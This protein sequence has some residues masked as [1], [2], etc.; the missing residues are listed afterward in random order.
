MES[1]A[2]PPGQ[3][4]TGAPPEH[5]ICLGVNIDHVA[6]L[7]NARGECYPDPVYAAFIA[8]QHGADSITTHLREDRRHITDRDVRL[9]AET[10]E[11]RLNLEMAISDDI[12]AIAKAIAPSAACLVPE[13]R[14]ELTTEGGLDVAQDRRRVAEAVEQLSRV[15]TT[16]S[17]FIDPVAEQIDAAREVGAPYVE[18]H[19]GAYAGARTDAERAGELSRLR[20]MAAYAASL[21]LHVNAG[22][23]LGYHN[24]EAVAAIAEIEELNIGHSIIARAVFSGLGEAVAAM[25]ALIRGARSTAL[26]AARGA[27]HE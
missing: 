9:I 25:K 3:S 11:T 24:V 26:Q 27:G 14:E 8:Q 19:T 15:G 21:G 10:I 12:M 6:T 13:R 20:E 7:R 22:H 23:G 2:P 1:S 5:V 16:V 17:L 4:G 18:F